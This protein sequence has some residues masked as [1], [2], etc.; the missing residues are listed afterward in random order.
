M[1]I[2]RWCVIASVVVATTTLA[3]WT[4]HVSL[5]RDSRLAQATGGAPPLVERGRAL[6]NDTGLSADGKSSCATCH[7]D[8]GHTDNKTYVGLEVVSNGDPRGRSTPTLWGAGRRAAYS[9]AGTAPSLG[10]N[11]RGIIVNRMKGAEPSA[12]TLAALV[13]Y[14]S[15]LPYPPNPYVQE[16][17]TPGDRAPAA[18]KR[19][20]ALFTGKA[21]CQA[22]HLLPNYDRKDLADVGSGGTFKVP[23]LRAVSRTAPYFHDGRY[24][25][26]EE[27][28]RAM[29][30]YLKKAGAQ[31]TLSDEEIRDLVAFL[32]IL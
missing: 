10:G 3:S 15:S 19:G 4:S 8:N 7:P 17:G 24:A 5:A 31:D 2:A 20:F 6:F 28:V 9:W 32:N 29:W 12:D 18:A 16:D 21:A 25:T 22:C 27:T 11:I 23:S 1:R 13:A 14:V 30:A 26:L